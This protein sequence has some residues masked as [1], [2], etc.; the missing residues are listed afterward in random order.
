VNGEREPEQPDSAEPDE[1]GELSEQ[2]PEEVS[3]EGETP[4]GSSDE[5]SEAPG[6][7][8]T[9]EVYPRGNREEED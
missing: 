4:L 1:A 6:P 7:H 5:H 9:G 3:G 2:V 8:G